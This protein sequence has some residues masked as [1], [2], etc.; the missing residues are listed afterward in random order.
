MLHILQVLSLQSTP[1]VGRIPQAAGA[2]RPMKA[3]T[4]IRTKDASASFHFQSDTSRKLMMGYS[5][6]YAFG[7]ADNG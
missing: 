2:D 4:R 7:L 3:T 1:S 6:L 5:G